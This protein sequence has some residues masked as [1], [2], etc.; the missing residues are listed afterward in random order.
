MPL[1]LTF[2]KHCNPKAMK[3]AVC[4]L[5]PMVGQKEANLSLCR[6]AII[7]SASA[8]AKIIV[9]PELANTGYSFQNVDELV[10]NAETIDGPSVSEWADLARALDIV[11]VA[12]FA[13]RDNAGTVF[14]SA[15]IFDFSGL[16]DVYRKVHL[17][18]SEKTI[19]SAG[20]SPPALV[21]TAHG[22]IG[23]MI[24]YDIEFP[25]W[26]RV[27]SLAGAELLCCP[28]NWPLCARPAAERPADI[29][30]VQAAAATNRMFIALADRCG[31]DRDHD[32]VGGSVIVDADGYP[33]T[34]ITLSVPGIHVADVD[35]AAA[36][37]KKV[38]ALND[39]FADRRPELYVDVMRP[40]QFPA[41][42]AADGL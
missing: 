3:I 1:P 22:R 40:R 32:W 25:E 41:A 42:H 8:G 31:V 9:L 39:V 30:R 12:G 4:Q 5:S 14:N 26:V 27:A 11:L 24:C 38:S 33:R 35:L 19:F 34:S 23:V 7:S 15:A 13:E 37:D 16:R 10:L 28:A 21:D 29:I 20:C 36:R 18:N 6:E 2:L 17:W